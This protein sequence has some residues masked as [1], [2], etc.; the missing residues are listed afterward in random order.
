M[1]LAECEAATRAWENPRSR[2]PR[3]AWEAIA[4]RSKSIEIKEPAVSPLPALR[5]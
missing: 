3:K 5:A 4:R 2:R 1:L